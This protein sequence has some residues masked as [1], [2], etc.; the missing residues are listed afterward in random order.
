MPSF[1]PQHFI[2]CWEELLSHEC[3]LCPKCLSRYNIIRVTA[4]G[5]LKMHLMNLM[6]KL[7]LGSYGADA[8]TV[9]HSNHVPLVSPFGS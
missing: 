5:S 2:S 3:L 6:F 1:V 4:L 8:A 7:T 9:T